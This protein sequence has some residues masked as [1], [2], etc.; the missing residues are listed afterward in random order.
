MRRGHGERQGTGLVLDDTTTVYITNRK[1]PAGWAHLVGERICVRARIA[2]HLSAWEPP[3]LVGPDNSPLASSGLE[4]VV[5]RELTLTG[6]ARETKAGAA[7]LTGNAEPV[8]I[9]GLAMWP[10]ELLGKRV[11]ASG[12]LLHIKHIPDPHQAADGAISQ[13]AVGLQYVLQRASWKAL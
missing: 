10:E 6:T 13:G 8:Y 11:S 1:P 9:K 7:L 4:R 2:P 3:V 5:G 12:R